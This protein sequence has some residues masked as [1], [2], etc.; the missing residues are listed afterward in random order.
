MEEVNIKFW[1]RVLLLGHR[2]SCAPT[3]NEMVFQKANTAILMKQLLHG[4]LDVCPF[5]YK[6][7]YK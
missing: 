2:Y 4:F 5:Y 6:I 7:P 1:I 3:K